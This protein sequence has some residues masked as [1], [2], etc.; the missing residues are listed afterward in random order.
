MK[1]AGGHDGKTYGLTGPELLSFGEMMQKMSAVIGKP[2]QHVDVPVA[3]ARDGMI[4]AGYPPE[5]SDGLLVYFAA[6]KAGKMFV[7]PRS[8]NYWVVRVTALTTTCA[9]TR[10]RSTLKGHVCE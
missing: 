10:R 2:L 6:V 8:S 9:P 4:G 1:S 7:Q 3:T 5:H